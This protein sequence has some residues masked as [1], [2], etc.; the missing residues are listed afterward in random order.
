MRRTVKLVVEH[1]NELRNFLWC[2]FAADGSISIG[3]SDRSFIV[4][5]FAEELYLGD[6]AHRSEIDLTQRH[7]VEAI[8]NPHFTFHPPGYVHLRANNQEELFAGVLMVDMIVNQDGHF[9]WVRFVSSPVHEL[10]LYRGGR[11]GEGD[12]LLMI[13]A[14]SSQQS[15]EMAV[16]IVKPGVRLGEENVIF[17]TTIRW[18]GRDVRLRAKAR[19]G[20][21]STF[22]WN[23]QS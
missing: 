20:T 22:Q 7:G 19:D 10:S 12:E 14:S 18:A 11:E 8:T 9:P 13:S 1:E 21:P 17:E 4:P 16:D 5:G 2:G 6:R 15:I 23:H 3:F